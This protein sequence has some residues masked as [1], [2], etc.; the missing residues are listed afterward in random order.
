MTLPTK[1]DKISD[2]DCISQPRALSGKKKGVAGAIGER[3]TQPVF[4]KVTPS[5]LDLGRQDLGSVGK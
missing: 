3:V 1:T 5:K 2:T 4:W